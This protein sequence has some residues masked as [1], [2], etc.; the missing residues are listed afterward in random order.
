MLFTM[1]EEGA[2]RSRGGTSAV[3]W[4][5]IAA[6]TAIGVTMLALTWNR[7]LDPY[8]DL[9]RNLYIPEQLAKGKV[10]YRDIIYFYPP[11]AP[12]LLALIVSV[13]GSGLTQYTLIGIATVVLAA[14]VIY[15]NLRQLSGSVAAIAAV[16][17]FLTLNMVGGTTWGSNFVFPYSHDTTF[18]MT[19]FLLALLFLARY[20]FE[21][22][23]PLRAAAAMTFAVLAA[24]TKLE[25]SVAVVAMILVAVIVYRFSWRWAAA[26]AVVGLALIGLLSLLFRDPRPGH[27]WI[28]D[29]VF[30]GA[31][32]GGSIPDF[33][34]GQVSGRSSISSNALQMVGGVVGIA[35]L[36]LLLRAIDRYWP[37]RP[38]LAAATAAL[39]AVGVYL[40]ANE[41]FFM[42]WTILIP[43]AALLGLRE[44]RESPLALLS[45][46]ALSAAL[47]VYFFLGPWWY[48]F[49]LVLPTYIL[50]A[51]VLFTFLPQRGVYSSRASLLW[52][53]L[54][55]V[56]AFRGATYSI[57]RL[58]P[59]NFEV[60][61]ARGSFLDYEDRGRATQQLLQAIEAQPESSTLAVMPEGLAINWFAK[62][63]TSLSYHTFTPIEIAAPAVEARIAGELRDAAPDLVAIVQRD[64][65][66][67]GFRGFG[68]DYAV[69]IRHELRRSYRPIARSGVRSFDWILL[70]RNTD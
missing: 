38:L 18:G 54:F 12:Y 30:T 19:F 58:A 41:A 49:V 35:L 55:A 32:I 14:T 5:C 61:T 65:S 69:G 24:S 8:I 2:P 60:R 68:D 10:L 15:L 26:A 11:A 53:A 42:A 16:M 7:W 17:L 50:I 9:G 44:G 6:L 67:F 33:F 45:V 57:D 37:T 64:V 25:Y 3:E 62:R 22:P 52:L 47:R 1:T 4:L 40:V 63:E 48:G 46:V 34:Y 29:N 28:R 36:V 56:L 70:R 13:I 23:G 43:V 51:Y 31:L 39:F 66:E 27:H 59:R 21:R 20:L